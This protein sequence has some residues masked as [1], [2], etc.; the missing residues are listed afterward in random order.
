MKQWKAYISCTLLSLLLAACSHEQ[1]GT[2]LLQGEI[3]GLGNDTIYL[4]GVDQ[5]YHHTDTITLKAGKY[6]SMLTPYRI[7]DSA[8][9]TERNTPS[10]SDQETV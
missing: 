7:H 10:I 4:Y 8:F 5:F 2:V 3:K 1:K 6:G 9:P